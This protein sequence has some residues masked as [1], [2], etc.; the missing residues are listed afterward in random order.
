MLRKL[1]VLNSDYQHLI[2]DALIRHFRAVVPQRLGL[3]PIPFGLRHG[4]RSASS[5]SVTMRS[6]PS[7]RERTRYW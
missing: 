5:V 4:Y 1:L 2:A 3:G 6:W 7:R